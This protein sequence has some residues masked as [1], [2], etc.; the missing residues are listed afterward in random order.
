MSLFLF[1][2][3]INNKL[4]N[5]KICAMI[6]KVLFTAS[7]FISGIVLLNAQC[8]PDP[9]YTSPGIYPDTITNLPHATATVAYNTTMTA[10]VPAD[11]TVIVTIP[12]DSIGITQFTGLPTGLTWQANTS[13]NYW[14][15]GTSG[16]VLISGTTTQVGIF[17]LSIQTKTYL[18]LGM[19]PVNTPVLGYKIV[20]DPITGINNVNLEKFDISQNS[21][22]PFSFKT[23]ILFTSP[24]AE[25]IQFTVYNL[26]GEV[27]YKESIN[28]IAGINE[29]EFTTSNLPSGIY[30]Y[31]INNKAQTV[32]KRMIIEGK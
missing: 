17:P 11:T 6:K 8:T 20:V 24:V 26:I 23:D 30:M 18:G 9:Q 31:Q 27:V 3:F 28:A 15:G 2:V 19:Q 14:H 13:S 5:L 22:N 7:L 1:T 16:C 10:V 25:T 29:I 32:T 21:P 12:I 4:I